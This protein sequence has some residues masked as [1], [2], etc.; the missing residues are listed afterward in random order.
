MSVIPYNLLA[1]VDICRPGNCCT[2]SPIELIIA[3]HFFVYSGVI[4]VP[5]ANFER[6]T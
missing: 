4:Q 5:C 1:S 6:Q 2:L 3:V